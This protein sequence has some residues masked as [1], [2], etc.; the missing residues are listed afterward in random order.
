[1]SGDR[2]CVKRP[3]D[4]MSGRPRPVQY[5]VADG[6]PPVC[7]TLSSLRGD[8]RYRLWL[9]AG[10]VPHAAYS[11]VA[12]ARCDRFVFASSEATDWSRRLDC[13]IRASI[14]RASA[15]RMA[16]S[17]SFTWTSD[18]ALIDSSR[19]T[20]PAALL[21]NRSS[22][23]RITFANSTWALAPMPVR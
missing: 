18:S 14:S 22:T 12:A 16:R 11:G 17:A 10:H 21:L 4:A 3:P 2:A 1:M 13:M 7:S 19:E 6:G 20:L 8:F 9:I 15:A 5:K 23:P